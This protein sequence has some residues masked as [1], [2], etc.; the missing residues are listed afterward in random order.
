MEAAEL[1]QLLYKEIPITQALQI[2]VDSLTSNS[3]QVS[4]PFEANKNIHNTAF[5]GSIYTTATLAGWS[6]VTH[7]VQQRQ[8]HGSVVL[9]SATI[10]YSKPINGDIVAS[11]QI[12]NP[13]IIEHFLKRFDSRGRGR[14]SLEID[15]I[16]AGESKA[17][18]QADFAVLR[19]G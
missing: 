14:L 11:C 12:A 19:Q 18:M 3:I 1:Q 16:E 5:A 15:V 6:L 8:R 10:R 17:T 4:A 9:A 2:Q 7:M 13:D